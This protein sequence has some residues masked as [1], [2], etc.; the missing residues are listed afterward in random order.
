MLLSTSLVASK[1]STSFPKF[2]L[3]YLL[4]MPSGRVKCLTVKEN[5]FNS[6]MKIG[7]G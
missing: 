5:L 4:C 1:F 7:N 3:K 2:L 6:Q